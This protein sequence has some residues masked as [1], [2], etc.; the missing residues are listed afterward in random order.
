M[1]DK[2]SRPEG[3]RLGGSLADRWSTWQ[4]EQA[5]S[6]EGP[7]I[8]STLALFAAI[9]VVLLVLLSGQAVPRHSPPEGTRPPTT[10][11]M[12]HGR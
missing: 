1:Q 3:R 10:T 6:N 2:P 9:T 5:G 11:E 7:S 4:A 8:G 12:P